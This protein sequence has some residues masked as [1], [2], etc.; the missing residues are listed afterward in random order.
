MPI[1]IDKVTHIVHCSILE[2]SLA[3]DF[4]VLPKANIN[5][6]YFLADADA[7]AHPIA[8]EVGASIDGVRL[9]PGYAK[10]MGNAANQLATVL[11]L[12]HLVVVV[13]K[14]LAS[15]L[16]DA[17]F[18][19]GTTK[20]NLMSYLPLLDK[21]FHL[22]TPWEVIGLYIDEALLYPVQILLQYD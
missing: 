13:F 8:I 7:K 11:H 9:V 17:Q 21:L 5:L 19:L 15:L 20:E 12:L 22:G 14:L 4:V 18:F 1:V 3:K 6:A 16:Q 2:Q 10:A